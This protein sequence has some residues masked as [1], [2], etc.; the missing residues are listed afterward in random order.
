[1]K[2]KAII[3]GVDT[4]L[5]EKQLEDWFV[6]NTNKGMVQKDITLFGEF[7]IEKSADGVDF[8]MSDG[9][10]DFSGERVSPNGWD[11]KT[12]KKNP[13]ILWS[14]DRMRPAIGRMKNVSIVDGKLTGK[15]E[16]ASKEVD[17]F[18]W[19]I[20]EKIKAGILSAGSVGYMPLEVDFPKDRKDGTKL[21]V[22][23]QRLH[24]FSMVNVPCLP[25][26]LAERSEEKIEDSK[27]TSVGYLKAMFPES[28]D[29]TSPL[30]AIFG[31]AQTTSGLS[32]LFD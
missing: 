18:A 19:S 4:T 5:N 15:A 10:L 20:G 27:D 7:F 21:I 3:G 11:L 32:N 28:E 13:I 14:H 31:D 25:S 2:I 26:A 16:F 24:E 1:M 29:T 22:K 12:Y 8:I 6:R 23:K 9:N 30:N 17:E